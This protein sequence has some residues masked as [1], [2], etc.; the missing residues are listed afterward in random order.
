MDN[1]SHVIVHVDHKFSMKIIKRIYYTGAIEGF[2]KRGKYLFIKLPSVF[3]T[4]HHANLGHWSIDGISSLP[5]PRHGGASYSAKTIQKYQRMGGHHKTAF[6]NTDRG[7]VEGSEAA[8][9]QIGG[10]PL[11]QIK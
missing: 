1:R 7:I 6:F 5:K 11:F 10:L 4:S 9:K 8:S 2:E 3:T